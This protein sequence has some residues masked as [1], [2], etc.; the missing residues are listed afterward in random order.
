MFAFL[1]SCVEFTVRTV[2][3][4][5]GPKNRALAKSRSQFRTEKQG[6]LWTNRD[7]RPIFKIPQ[8]VYAIQDPLFSSLPHETE[9]HVQSSLPHKAEQHVSL[10]VWFWQRRISSRAPRHGSA[11]CSWQPLHPAYVLIPPSY[12]AHGFKCQNCRKLSRKPF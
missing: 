11:L 9:K 12:T 8:G 6:S 4:P 5:P 7:K 3:R 1:C 2:S 10:V